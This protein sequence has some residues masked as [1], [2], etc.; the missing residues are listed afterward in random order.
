MA[1]PELANFQKTLAQLK[2]FLAEPIFSDR[3][4]AGVIQAFNFTFEQSWKAIR[5][6]GPRVGIQVGNPKQAFMLAIQ[7]GWIQRVDEAKW[8]QI[9]D[10]RN[11]TSHTYKEELARLVLTRIQADYVKMFDDLLL[12]LGK[13]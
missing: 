1:N 5:K 11:L 2:L 12:R 8:I 9:L 10:D 4:R 13:V 6:I 7:S 3:D